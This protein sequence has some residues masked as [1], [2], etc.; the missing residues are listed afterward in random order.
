MDYPPSNRKRSGVSLGVCGG[1]LGESSGSGG[2]CQFSGDVV[3]CEGDGQPFGL[4][5]NLDGLVLNL[6]D[7]AKRSAAFSRERGEA[8]AVP[9][10]EPAASG[11][12]TKG[13]KLH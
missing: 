8:D 12:R 4:G 10:I 1:L 11:G 9:I 2:G 7:R 6:E 5:L 3:D 13:P